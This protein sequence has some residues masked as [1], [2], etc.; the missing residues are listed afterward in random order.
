MRMTSA[1]NRIYGMT[2]D[3]RICQGGMSA[4]KTFSILQ[5]LISLAEQRENKVISI[6]TDVL[7]TLKQGALRDFKRILRETGHACYFRENLTEC[8]FLCTA[9]GTKVEFFGIEN[10]LKARGGRRDY[11]FVNEANRISFEVFDQMYARTSG[12]TFI[13]FNPSARFWAHDIADGVLPQFKNRAE[14]EVFT[15]RDNEELEPKLVDYI[16]SHDR[17]SNWWRVYG[18]GKI[19]ELEGNVFNNWRFVEAP[20]TERRLLAYGLDFGFSPDPCALVSLWRVDDGLVAQQEFLKHGLTP[21]RIVEEVSRCV[22]ADVPIVYD[23]AREEIGQELRDAGL[24]QAIACV[25]QEKFK[26]PNGQSALVGK[27]GQLE[28]MAEQPFVAIGADLEREYLTYAY[29]RTR[30]GK[31]TPVIPDGN[32]H[33]IDALRY[34]WY[35]WY[36]RDKV[37]AALAAT[38]EEYGK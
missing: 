17:K 25:K 30:D 9:T 8:T 27:A 13:D 23:H 24:A 20:P 15:Y 28:K 18:E 29:K 7:P 6:V 11:L 33:L 34:A 10:E 26:Q 2:A 21:S 38:I 32:D 19:G 4:G 36:R 22:R 35:W 31:F 5:Y 12:F 1:Y 16:E 37:A 3:L 14:L